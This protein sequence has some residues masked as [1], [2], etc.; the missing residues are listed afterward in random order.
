MMLKVTELGNTII[1]E[2]DFRL[3]LYNVIWILSLCVCVCVGGGGVSKKVMVGVCFAGVSH[4]YARSYICTCS[5]SGLINVLWNCTSDLASS[6]L[7]LIPSD[8]PFWDLPCLNLSDVMLQCSTTKRPIP[9]LQL[10][11]EMVMMAIALNSPTCKP[12]R[13]NL[14]FVHSRQPEN[15]EHSN[16]LIGHCACKDCNGVMVIR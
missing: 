1:M 8:Q 6:S 10:H 11:R 16:P 9:K 2:A 7:F 14:A 5:L 15:S 12:K 13:T 4:S 3:E